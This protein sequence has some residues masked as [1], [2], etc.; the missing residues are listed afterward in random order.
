MPPIPGRRD[1]EIDLV[2]SHQVG[3]KPRKKRAYCLPSD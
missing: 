2:D 3:R 1:L